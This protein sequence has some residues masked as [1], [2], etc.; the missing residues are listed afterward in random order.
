M[1]SYLVSGASR[2]IGRAIA[3]SLAQ[4][5]PEN[6]VI[7]LG[8]RLESLEAVLEELPN[9]RQHRTVV[10]DLGDA[11]ELRLS[12]KEAGLERLNLTAVVACAG[13]GGENSFGEEDRWDE[14][15]RTNLSGTYRLIQECLPALR[16]SQ[17]SSRS[18]VAISSIL[19]RIG[20]PKYNAYCASKAGLLGLVRSLAAELAPE[21]ILVNAVCPGWVDTQMSTEGLEA[22]ARA[23]GERFEDV[24]AREMARV[25]LGKMS[26]PR[27]IAELVRFLV[28]GA[29]TSI[30]GQSIDINNGAWMA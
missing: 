24:R 30:T 8:R 3:S 5:D 18:I 15:I 1:R 7:L 21:R 16:A 20:V 13:I 29:Q 9:P 23:S 10:A 27:E 14:I 6:S 4:A 28:S 17:E 26:Q 12:L 22:M 19:A 2:G 11:R 25:P